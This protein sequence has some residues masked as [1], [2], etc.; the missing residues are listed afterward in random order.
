MPHADVGPTLYLNVGIG[1]LQISI[2]T[3]KESNVHNAR[4]NKN[5]LSK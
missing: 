4:I 5:K 1:D 3:N 2:E